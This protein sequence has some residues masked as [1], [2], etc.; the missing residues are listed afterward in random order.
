MAHRSHEFSHCR[1]NPFFRKY[2]AHSSFLTSSMRKTSKDPSSNV[3]M[4]SRIY[5]DQMSSFCSNYD[6]T[7]GTDENGPPFMLTDELKSANSSRHASLS[8]GKQL[9]EDGRSHRDA[10]FSFFKQAVLSAQNAKIKD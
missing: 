7:L 5:Q 6:F 2:G 4:E 8:L 10:Q 1:K 3:T 9:T